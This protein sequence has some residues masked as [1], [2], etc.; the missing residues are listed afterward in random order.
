M[1][2]L[3]RRQS[4][5]RWDVLGAA[6][7]LVWCARQLV[8]VVVGHYDTNLLL[9]RR[10]SFSSRCASLSSFVLLERSRTSHG[11]HHILIDQFLLSA[12]RAGRRTIALDGH[13]WNRRVSL[14]DSGSF[15]VCSRKKKWINFC[16]SR[17]ISRS[18]ILQTDK[19][20]KHGRSADARG[21]QR[22]LLERSLC[23][24]CVVNGVPNSAVSRS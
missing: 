5:L 17:G 7:G 21:Q 20:S 8:F 3:T 24:L 11:F 22:F 14:R 15:F 18:W 6:V 1:I 13:N 16:Q 2:F 9:K 4:P 19:S 10:S 12:P 23:P